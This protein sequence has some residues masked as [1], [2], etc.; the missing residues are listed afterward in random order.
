MGLEVWYFVTQVHSNQNQKK[1][2]H[3]PSANILWY[4]QRR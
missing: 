1:I 3:I 2:T 4:Q